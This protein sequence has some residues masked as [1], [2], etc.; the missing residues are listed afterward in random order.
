MTESAGVL[1]PLETEVMQ[2][3]WKAERP[4]VVRD[5]LDRLNRRRTRPLAYTTV[6]TVLAR[7]AEKH[8]LARVK[9][10][11]S[12]VYEPLVTDLAGVAV[13]TVIRDYGETA[14]AHFVEQARGDPKL[15]ARLQRLMSPDQ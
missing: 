8:V 12:Y 3:L 2:V 5:V 9:E 13:Q 14:V 10:G 15:L 4:L 6:M 1:G 11:R 7:L